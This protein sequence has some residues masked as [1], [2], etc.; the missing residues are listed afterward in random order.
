MNRTG[1]ESTQTT[2]MSSRH[3]PSSRFLLPGLTWDAKAKGTKGRT[4]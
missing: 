1:A 2:P 3:C 4:I